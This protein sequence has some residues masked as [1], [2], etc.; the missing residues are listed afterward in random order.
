MDKTLHISEDKLILWISFV[1]INLYDINVTDKL[2]NTTY[3]VA[4][5]DGYKY[6]ILNEK[7]FDGIYVAVLKQHPEIINEIKKFIEYHQP[8]TQTFGAM[9]GR[10]RNK[11]NTWVDRKKKSIKS[12]WQKK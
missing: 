6:N 5:Y 10:L 8:E 3:R 7:S 1:N 11:F 2:T 9:I 4:E 12:I